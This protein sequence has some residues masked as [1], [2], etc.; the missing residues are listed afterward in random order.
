MSDTIYALSSGS[1]PSGVAVVRISGPDAFWAFDLFHVK[2]PEPRLAK[3]ARLFGPDG[4]LIDQA[5]VLV[6]PAPAS[7]TGED[8]VE[9]H[10]HG[11]TAIVERVFSILKSVDGFRPADRGEFTLRAYQNGKIDLVEAEG[12]ADLIEAQT[13]NQRVQALSQYGGHLSRL[14]E[15]WRTRLLALRAAAEADFDFSDEEDVS[16]SVADRISQDARCLAKDLSS[17]LDDGH[18]GQIIR[19]GLKVVIAG[20]PNAGKSSLLNFLAKRDVA[21]VTEEAGTTRDVLTVSLNL[22]GQLFILSDTAGLR[23]TS[24]RIEMEGIRRALLTMEDANLVLWAVPAGEAIDIEQRPRTNAPV[25]LIRTKC[26]LTEPSVSPVVDG[27]AL[28]QLAISVRS[29]AGLPQLTEALGRFG[30]VSAGRDSTERPLVTRH[31]HRIA[32]EDCVSALLGASDESLPLEIRVDYLRQGSDALGKVLG[33]ID[34]EDVLGHIFSEFC[35][36]K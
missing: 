11:G 6:F 2:Q 12:L 30:S 8:V 10:V 4:V 29:G 9:L 18:R 36:G 13:E 3:L 20:P 23:E 17:Y 16:G 1:L 33:R 22:E 5:L 27:I 19:D 7:F 26:D 31:R 35:I 21:I 14:F 32:L 34:V 15:D 25:W 24:D 28:K